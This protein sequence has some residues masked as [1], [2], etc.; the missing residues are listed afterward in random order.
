ME[1]HILS[2]SAL[3]LYLVFR[4]AISLL[5]KSL[6]SFDFITIATT[7]SGYCI[8]SLTIILAFVGFIFFRVIDITKPLGCRWLDK[9]IHGGLGCMLDDA[10]AGTYALILTLLIRNL[11]IIEQIHDIL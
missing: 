8:I 11:Q 2:I 5:T 9:N 6:L 3:S 10:L 7:W 1:S 4:K